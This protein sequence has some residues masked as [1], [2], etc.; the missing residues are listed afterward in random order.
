MKKIEQRKADHIEVSMEEKVTSDY[1]YWQDI[2]LIHSALPEVDKERIDASVNF[3][4]KELGFPLIVTAITGGF[5]QAKRINENLARA[6]ENLQIGMGVGSQRA[7]LEEGED[8]SYSVIK[9][10]DIPLKIG[11]IGA[12]QLIE[13]KGKKK[14][15]SEQVRY[16]LD[17][18]DGDIMAVHLNFLQEVVQPEGETNS[19]GCLEKIREL[20]RELPIMVKETGA[21]ISRKTA[22][23]LKSTGVKA[24]DVAGLGG[25]SFSAVE[26]YRA[27]RI[28]DRRGMAVGETF[29]DWGIP[30]PVSVLWADTGIPMVASGGV[31]SG[32]DIARG[33]ALG[34]DCSGMAGSL[35]KAALNSAQEVERTLR[36]IR[37]EFVAAL[38]LTGAENVSELRDR[39]LIITGRT[40]EWLSSELK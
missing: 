29:R 39:D 7:A 27:K 35:V 12:P 23:L 9:E 8:G 38:F 13:Q 1:N 16:A 21:G 30:S 11:N 22:S 4:G 36:M 31:S 5:K 10:Y 18:I 34:A 32:I 37:E 33:I 25:T 2:K 24:I 40:R 28:D 26:H 17:M 15:G 19:E 14:I 6:C 3:L 20:S